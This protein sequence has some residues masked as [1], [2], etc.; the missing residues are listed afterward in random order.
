MLPKQINQKKKDPSYLLGQYVGTVQCMQEALRAKENPQ[1]NS[2]TIG[3]EY[4]HEVI[5]NPASAILRIEA[6]LAPMKQ[7][8]HFIENKQL[9]KEMAFI[10]L[11]PPLEQQMRAAGMIR[12]PP[13]FHHSSP[14]LIL[15]S[16]PRSSPLSRYAYLSLNLCCLRWRLGSG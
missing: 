12:S 7:R 8:M 2:L 14:S 13:P 9:L 3:E 5:E 11:Y 6:D 10:S 1:D 15:S 4:F 16:P